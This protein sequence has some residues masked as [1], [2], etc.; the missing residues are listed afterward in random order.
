MFS[1]H[2]PHSDKPSLECIPAVLMKPF[3]GKRHVLFTDNY[4]AGL[5]LAKSIDLT[6]IYVDCLYKSVKQPCF[7]AQ[8]NKPNGGN[9]VESRE[10]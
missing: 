2:D 5:T 1:K 10:R 4:Y 3:L 8:E 7:Y 6:Q 9:K